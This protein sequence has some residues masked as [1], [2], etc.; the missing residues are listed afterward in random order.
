MIVATSEREDHPTI[1]LI[2]DGATL[3]AVTATFTFP[4][5]TAQVAVFPPSAVVT[6][7]V[8]IPTAKE[9]PLHCS[10]WRPQY[11]AG[12]GYV[13]IGGVCRSYRRR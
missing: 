1:S 9:S 3:T 4:M 13:S 7:I 8:L 6:V 2:A 5:V 11:T 12:P 10:P